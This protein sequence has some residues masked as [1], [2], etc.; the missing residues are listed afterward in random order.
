MIELNSQMFQKRRRRV[1]KQALEEAGDR[2]LRELR[3]RIA[4]RQERIAQLELELFDTRADLARFEHEME[5]RLGVLKIHIAKLEHRVEAAKRSAARRAQWGDRADSPDVPE[6]VV[7]QFRRRWKQ[8]NRPKPEPPKKPLDEASKEE[9]KSMFR[10]LAKRFH[11]D[12][13]RN[14]EEKQWRE[15]RMAEV[16]MAYAELDMSALK[17]MAEVPDWSPEVTQKSREQE[18]TELHIEI[19][20]LDDVITNLERTLRELINSDTVKLMLDVSIARNEGRDLLGHIESELLA[21]IASLEK[22]LAMIG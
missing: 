3:D 17:T 8:S 4:S 13:A 21:K 7:E 20:R 6:D 19:Q 1:L 15:E 11:P 14:P 10:S 16:N 18:I 2:E 22:E 9:F 5:G 12:L